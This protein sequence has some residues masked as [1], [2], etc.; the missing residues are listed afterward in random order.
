MEDRKSFIL[1]FDS[2]DVIDELNDTQIAGLF[3]AMRDYNLWNEVKLDWLMKA[4]FIPFKNQFDRDIEKYKNI[5][6]RNSLNGAKWWRPKKSKETQSVITKPKQAY[7]DS[8]ND[9]E[10]KN[11]NNNKI[12]LYKPIKQVFQEDSFEYIISKSFLDFH[13]QDQTPS[14]LYLINSKWEQGILNNWADEI[15]KLKEIDKFTEKQIKF[16]ID[17]TLRDDFWKNQIQSIEKFRKKK[18]WISYFVKMIDKAKEWAKTNLTLNPNLW[19][20]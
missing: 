20:L 10:S 15:R 13:K 8:D 14:I 3:K 6:D 12:E 11:D 19:T 9:N 5:C 1:H 7:N 17:F 16:I 4:V 2:L 18:D